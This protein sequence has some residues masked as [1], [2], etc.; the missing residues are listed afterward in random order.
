MAA[1]HDN[2]S[3]HNDHSDASSHDAHDE[4]PEVP[5]ADE[6]T[7]VTPW[8]M[9]LIGLSLLVAFAMGTYLFVT[10]SVLSSTA[11]DGGTTADASAP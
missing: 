11:G 5:D 4:H 8:W 1:A 10:P 9:P 6:S 3:A 2:H 7:I